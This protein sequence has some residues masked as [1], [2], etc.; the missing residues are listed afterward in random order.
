MGIVVQQRRFWLR[1]LLAV[2]AA[3]AELVSLPIPVLNV[4]S[5]SMPWTRAQQHLMLAKGM[6]SPG[7]ACHAKESLINPKITKDLLQK[8]GMQLSLPHLC[9]IRTMSQLGLVG[10]WRGKIH[11]HRPNLSCHLVIALFLYLYFLRE[12]KGDLSPCWFIL[13]RRIR[14]LMLCDLLKHAIAIVKYLCKI[15]KVIS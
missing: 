14:L 6:A 11:S 3:L 2:L 7:C 9:P 5:L 12:M 4:T 15:V 8:N 1:T 10:A 13:K